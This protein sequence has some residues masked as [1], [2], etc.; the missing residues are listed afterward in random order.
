[1]YIFSEYAKSIFTEEKEEK[2]KKVL[3][4]II[5]NKCKNA[6]KGQKTT[7]ES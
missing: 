1:M 3:D 4:K 2:I 5:A 7:N 6:Y